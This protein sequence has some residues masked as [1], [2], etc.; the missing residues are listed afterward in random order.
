MVPAVAVALVLL[1]LG[2]VAADAHQQQVELLHVQ[3]AVAV[4]V[5]VPDE[6]VHLRAP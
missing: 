6:V 5:D 3:R 1:G 4:V 2:E